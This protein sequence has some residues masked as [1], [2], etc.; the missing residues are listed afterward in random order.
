M[1]WTGRDGKESA[2][3]LPDRAGHHG[4][5]AGRQGRVR[6]LQR[7]PEQPCLA[8]ELGGEGRRE[9]RS[10]RACFPPLHFF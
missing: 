9:Q 3:S 8:G 4:H 10:S 5:L 2:R 1:I 7:G 6:D